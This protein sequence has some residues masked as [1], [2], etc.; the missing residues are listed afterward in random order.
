M[1]CVL[2]ALTKWFPCITIWFLLG[3]GNGSELGVLTEEPTPTNS[4]TLADRYCYGAEYTSNMGNQ[5]VSCGNWHLPDLNVKACDDGLQDDLYF[6]VANKLYATCWRAECVYTSLWLGF[7]WDE[8][9]KC[10][11]AVYNDGNQTD[12]WE[13]NEDGFF[14][15]SGEL[16]TALDLLCFDT[17]APTVTPTPMPPTENPTAP[18]TTGPTTNPTETPTKAPTETPTVA[19][20]EKPTAVPTTAPTQYPSPDP[21]TNPTQTPTQTP[22]M[23]PTQTPTQRTAVPTTAPTQYPSP[24]PTTNPTQTPTQTPTMTPTLT[25]TQKP[26]MPATLT[27]TQNPTQTPSQKPSMTPTLTPTQNPTKT[28]TQT[29]TKNPTRTPTQTPIQ[30]PTLTP[31]K[32]PT[33]ANTSS[34][35]LSAEV[36]CI[37]E[38]EIADTIAPLARVLNVL[39]R[40]ISIY[41]YSEL[42]LNITGLEVAGFLIHYVAQVYDTDELFG[43]ITADNITNEFAQELATEFNNASCNITVVSITA[44]RSDAS[45]DGYGQWLLPLI[46]GVLIF[47]LCILC[48]MYLRRRAKSHEEEDMNEGLTPGTEMY[49][50]T[51]DRSD[52][53]Q[54]TAGVAGETTGTGGGVITATQT[55]DGGFEL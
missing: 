1:N 34:V 55:P 16:A 45:T 49:V 26:T 40:M 47:L 22:T 19:S 31:T 54:S 44:S 27:P 30:R 36:S 42:T 25:P 18:P 15:I 7:R 14:W 17:Q 5:F 11:F 4:P 13:D 43:L 9:N 23:T 52:F 46:C 10:Y 51:T 41:S 24:D 32:I 37:T 50:Q 53:V 21:T 8:W 33:H 35:L 38:K 20:T 39:E 48:I 12:C 2:H 6:G 28:P 3:V 29:P